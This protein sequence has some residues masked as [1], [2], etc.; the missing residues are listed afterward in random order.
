M[1]DTGVTG[2]SSVM[3]YCVVGDGGGASVALEGV[4]GDDDG[5]GDAAGG[6]GGDVNGSVV[7]LLVV[8][9]DTVVVAVSAMNGICHL[10]RIVCW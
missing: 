8:V 7:V 3:A 4:D 10:K 5:D 1:V 6:A 2:A 9:V